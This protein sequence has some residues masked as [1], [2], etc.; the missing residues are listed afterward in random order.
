[1]SREKIGEFRLAIYMCK[2]IIIEITYY[3][4]NEIYDGENREEKNIDTM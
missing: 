1:V 4:S 3:K 2:Y